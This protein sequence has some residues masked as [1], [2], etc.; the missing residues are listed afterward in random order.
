MPSRGTSANREPKAQATAHAGTRPGPPTVE[1]TEEA[2]AEMSV[3]H[4]IAAGAATAGA[5]IFVGNECS[6]S[7]VIILPVDIEG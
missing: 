6:L 3:Q 4:A 7:T 5:R 1:H 2:T